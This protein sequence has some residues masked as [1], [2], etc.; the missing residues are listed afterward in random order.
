MH[1]RLS[2]HRPGSAGCRPSPQTGT[3]S[4][5]AAASVWRG[6]AS[7]PIY[8][9]ISGIRTRFAISCYRDD[10]RTR[11]VF[12]SIEAAKKRALLSTRQVQAG[13]GKGG[14]A[15]LKVGFRVAG[16]AMKASIA[17]ALAEG[18]T[19]ARAGIKAV[20]ATADFEQTKV[21]FPTRSSRR[22]QL[23]SSEVP[24]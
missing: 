11:Q 9:I 17:S 20:T 15:A 7:F 19:T 12:R 10:K 8:R 2:C 16:T 13:A 5:D 22:R 21:T 4:A 23:D 24:A 14:A 18:M 1:E 6:S 3:H